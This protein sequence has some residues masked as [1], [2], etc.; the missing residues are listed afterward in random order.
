MVV[1]L[2][3]TVLYY[4]RNGRRLEDMDSNA[5]PGYALMASRGSKDIV[6]WRCEN[7]DHRDVRYYS[8]GMEVDVAT[9]EAWTGGKVQP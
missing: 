3:G 2:C 7:G 4:T 6:E 1:S 5:S 8:D 9:V